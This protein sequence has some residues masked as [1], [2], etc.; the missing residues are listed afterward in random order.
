MDFSQNRLS[1]FAAARCGA[2][3]FTVLLRTVEFRQRNGRLECVEDLTP[4]PSLLAFVSVE[5]FLCEVQERGL[6]C[7]DTMFRA[8][9]IDAPDLFGCFPV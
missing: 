4:V 3:C 6:L 7:I 1:L 9:K 8:A 5:V 2:C